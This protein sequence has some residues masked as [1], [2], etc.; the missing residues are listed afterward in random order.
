[1]YVVS[2]LSAL[3]VD[4]GQNN[5]IGTQL[6]AYRDD[7]ES[8]NSRISKGEHAEKRSFRPHKVSKAEI[9]SV[10]FSKFAFLSYH[11]NKVHVDVSL[12]ASTV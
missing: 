4:N 5:S 1:M 6:L 11:T 8:G 12:Y 7:R 3:F 2:W 9:E 10:S